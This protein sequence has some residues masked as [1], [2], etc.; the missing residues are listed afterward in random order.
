[1]FLYLP[2]A[3]R[4]EKTGGGAHRWSASHKSGFLA[5]VEETLDVDTPPPV[6]SF[7][8]WVEVSI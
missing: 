1:M 7:C 5:I 2:S 8:W 6:K 4:K 3:D